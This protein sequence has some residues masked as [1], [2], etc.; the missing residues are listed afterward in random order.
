MPR[1]MFCVK[2]NQ[3]ITRST[4]ISLQYLYNFCVP[5]KPL[6]IGW[7]NPNPLTYYDV[8]WIYIKHQGYTPWGR[9]GRMI[10]TMWQ[11]I[12]HDDEDRI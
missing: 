6:E 1:V 2:F 7:L 4:Q 9:W 3:F 11:N 10:E 8:D 5:H 12:I